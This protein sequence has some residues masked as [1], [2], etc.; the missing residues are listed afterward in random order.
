MST[1]GGIKVFSGNANR[2]LT[3]EIC[4][5]LGCDPGSATAARFSD[6]EFNFQITENVRGGDVFIVQPTCPPTDANLM[7]LLVMLDAFRRSSAE[8]VTAVIPYFGY[9]RSDKKDRP[10]VSIAAK[11]VSNLICTAGADR[12]LTM[13]LHAAQIQGFFDI[14]VDH[15]YAAPVI[16]EHY[17]SHPL[18]RLTV[19]APDTGGAERARAY[20]KRLD[21][22]LAL[23]D[24]RR[25]K[26]NV[27]EVMN[28]VGD[29]RE[30][31]CLIIDDMCDTGGSLTKVAAALKQAGA[32]RVDACFTHPVLSGQAC[33]KLAHSDLEQ[34]VTTNTIPLGDRAC[35]SGNIEVLS[36]APLLAKAIKSIHEETSVSSLFV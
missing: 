1:T 22:E 34:V 30:R 35:A 3:Q 26:A 11:L 7:E 10:R 31:N 32:A 21:A 15:L 12:I 18:P 28:V 14:P 5:Y 4:A 17:Q 13:D 36:I 6:G 27:A 8:R 29:V 19:V 2:A 24:K 23:C 16:I 9:A 33:E 25:E 20:A